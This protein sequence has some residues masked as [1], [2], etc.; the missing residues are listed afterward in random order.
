MQDGRAVQCSVVCKMVVQCNA[1]QC[2]RWQIFYEFLTSCNLIHDT[3]GKH[4][5]QFNSRD[6]GQAYFV[7]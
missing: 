2:A 3:V 7:I 4:I 5:L 1:V 6:C